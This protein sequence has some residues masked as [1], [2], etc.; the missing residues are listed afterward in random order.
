M[1][2]PVYAWMGWAQILSPTAERFSGELM[3]LIEGAH[4]IAR[5]KYEKRTG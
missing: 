2:H 4:G 1:P 3:P 5:K